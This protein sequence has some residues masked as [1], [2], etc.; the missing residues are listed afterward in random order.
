MKKDELTIE[1]QIIFKALVEARSIQD[2]LWGRLN[3]VFAEMNVAN[4][5]KLFQKR[6]DKISILN[7]SNPH[8]KVELKKRL[9]QQAALSILAL[10]VLDEQ[11]KTN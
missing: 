10:R 11:E 3:S 8:A 2:Y 7:A 6:V 1:E 4:F 9:L 5:T